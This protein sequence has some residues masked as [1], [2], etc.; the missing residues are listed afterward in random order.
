MPH[1]AYISIDL[2]KE[3]KKEMQMSLKKQPMYDP[4]L[5][6]EFEAYMFSKNTFTRLSFMFLQVLLYAFRP[7]ICCPRRLTPED[8]IG[9]F[10]QVLY[11]GSAWYVSGIGGFLY[12]LSA[13]FLG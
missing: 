11:I 12:L 7:Q 3:N 8:V 2:G 10:C 4:D 9:A 1:H 6:T 5:P 13:T